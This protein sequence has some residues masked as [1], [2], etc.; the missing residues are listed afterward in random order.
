VDFRAETEKLRRHG[1]AEAGAAAGHQDF[2]ACE[3]TI[4]EHGAILP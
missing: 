4:C 1:F 2:A 3:K